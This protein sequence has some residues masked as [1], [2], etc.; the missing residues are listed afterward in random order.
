VTAPLSPDPAADDSCIF[1]AIVAGRVPSWQ[2]YADEHAVAFL[3]VSPWHRGH[4]LVVPRRHI[5]DLVT[6]APA[7][8][9]IAPAVD[10]VARLLTRRLAADGLNLLSSAGPVAGQEVRHL[11]IHVIPRYADEPGLRHLINPGPA[12]EGELES[13]YARIQA[14]G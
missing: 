2:V 13:V 8:A 11:H 5:P 7:L 10:A 12:P 1:C 9:E 4:T 3:D 6:G 14:D